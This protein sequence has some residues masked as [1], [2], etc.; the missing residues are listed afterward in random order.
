MTNSTATITINEA[1]VD[2]IAEQMRTVVNHY[3]DE[4]DRTEADTNRMLD[5][6]E[7]ALVSPADATD[8]Y[9]EYFAVD[10]TKGREIIEKLGPDVTLGD[11][12]KAIKDGAISKQW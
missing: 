5:Y 7:K 4:T 3:R 12:D 11:L 2:A 8:A 10:P 9:F 1:T 6:L